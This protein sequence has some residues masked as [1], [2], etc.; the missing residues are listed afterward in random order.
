MI[1]KRLAIGILSI[2]LAGCGLFPQTTRSLT[3][4][5]S[6]K[7]SKASSL[8]TYDYAVDQAARTA[9]ATLEAYDRFAVQIANAKTAKERDELYRTTTDL[10]QG[11]IM[12]I[13][14]IVRDGSS[15]QQA[16]PMRERIRTLANSGLPTGPSNDEA[17]T[18]LAYKA[19]LSISVIQAYD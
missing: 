10:L 6:S 12:S 17:R 7:A 19:L 15:A 14:T 3:N 18:K 8:E 13:L 9:K 5:P 4:E 11:A 1:R 2:L 16:S